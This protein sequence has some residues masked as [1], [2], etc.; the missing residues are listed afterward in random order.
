RNPAR[1]AL[2]LSW[3]PRCHP[4]SLSIQGRGPNRRTASSLLKRSLCLT[5]ERGH[6]RA[7]R[8]VSFAKYMGKLKPVWA[9]PRAM[10]GY[11][12]AFLSVAATLLVAQL[13]FNLQAAPDSLFLCAIMFTA[14]IGGLTAGAMAT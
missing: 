6:P 3:V 9:R 1:H 2:S 11:A 8:C 7:D 14:C 13:Q 4:Q 12:V 5:V 10:L